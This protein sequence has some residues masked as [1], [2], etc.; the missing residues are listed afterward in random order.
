[1][2]FALSLLGN[3]AE[4]ED[5]CQEMVVQMLKHWESFEGDRNLKSWAFTI[6]YRKCLDQ[7]KKRK[8]FLNFFNRAEVNY[9]T[10]LDDPAE[11]YFRLVLEKNPEHPRALTELGDLSF[12]AKQYEQ[13]EDFL[14]Q[15]L[16]LDSD[17]PKAHLISGLIFKEKGD[18][19]EALLHFKSITSRCPDHEEAIYYQALILIEQ[20]NWPQALEVLNSLVGLYGSYEIYG[21]SLRALS[22]LM[23]D[24]LAEAESDCRRALAISPNYY[25]PHFILGLISFQRENWSEASQNF[26]KS[27]KVDKTFDDGHYYL[28][29]AY[30]KLGRLKEGQSEIKRAAQL[31]EFAV[32]QTEQLREQALAWGWLKKAEL[33]VKRKK[34]IES[35]INHCQELLASK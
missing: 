26:L 17:I 18:Y 15:A 12:L 35:K 11:E 33:L 31:F 2:S 19:E 16:A 1:M 24:N 28:G 25:L 21:Y 23:L 10:S 6:L 3:K 22:Y 9:Q 34:E 7:L 4:A 29:Q 13:A 8:R 32:R 27:L 30:L 14:R 20:A 5:A